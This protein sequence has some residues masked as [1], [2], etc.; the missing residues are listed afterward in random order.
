MFVQSFGGDYD[1]RRDEPAA[2]LAGRRDSVERGGGT[3]IDDDGGLPIF[4]DGSDGVD[5]P[6][7]ANLTWIVVENGDPG[8]LVCDEYG[9]QREVA[10]DH[11]VQNWVERRHY[12]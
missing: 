12:G 2:I 1:S 7:G 4:A 10:L 11:F 5:D 3:E 8:I 9:L 6:V